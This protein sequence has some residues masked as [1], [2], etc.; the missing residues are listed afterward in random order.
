MKVLVYG[1]YHKGNIGDDLFIQ[2]FKHLFPD[3]D[4]V[5]TEVITSE[6]LRGIDVVFLGG[7]SFLHDS[8]VIAPTALKELESKKIF[9]LGVGVEGHIHPKHLDLMSKA[10]L[11]ATRSLDQVA[12][13]KAIGNA[14]YVPDLV[15]SLQDKVR[16]SERTSKSVLI[17][18]NVSVLPTCSNPHWKHA[19]WTYFKSEFCQFLDVL[20]DDGWTPSFFSMCHAQQLEDDWASNE[21]IGHMVRR[22]N[23]F[24][25]TDRPAKIEEVTQL[26][27]SY[28]L[29]ITQ[30]FHG[31][32]LSE[33]TRTPYI[34]IHHHDKL[35]FSQPGEGTFLS[36]Y[37]GSKQSFIDAFDKSIKMKF[38][39]ELP[40]EPT[41]FKAFTTEVV[42]L[43]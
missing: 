15:Y 21:L 27:S 28:D 31:I 1:W 4:F 10:K 34:S 36:Y 42:S 35:K 32:V 3:L 25:L 8:P 39:S 26:I 37:N 30:R 19:S 11:I 40:V 18:P 22:N 6:K 41:T 17:M 5:F 33:M 16:L 20:V 29:V 13:L 12:K 7:G 24:F 38:T 9:Y 43:L 2:A 23:K 14:I